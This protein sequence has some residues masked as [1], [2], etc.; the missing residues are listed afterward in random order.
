MDSTR[1][2]KVEPK[3]VSFDDRESVWDVHFHA[4]DNNLC[5]AFG[6]KRWISDTEAVIILF[7]SDRGPHFTFHVFQADFLPGSRYPATTWV[8][9]PF[10]Q[11]GPGG[12]AES[13]GQSAVPVW[14]AN[15][16]NQ[17]PEMVPHLQYMVPHRNVSHQDPEFIVPDLSNAELAGQLVRDKMRMLESGIG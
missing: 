6:T 13:V 9:L 1:T 2:S 3:F 11:P 4:R 5:Y 7:S 17:W 14:Y 10:P 8:A 16:V 15:N 12:G